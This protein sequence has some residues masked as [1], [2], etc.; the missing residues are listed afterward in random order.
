ML[1]Y[2]APKQ[3][4][5]LPNHFIK[6]KFGKSYLVWFQK[7]NL[8]IRLEEPAWFVFNKLVKRW[9]AGTIALECAARYGL[10]NDESS[11]YVGDIRS[12]IEKM[13]QPANLQWRDKKFSNNIQ[14]HSFEPFAKHQYR[15]NNKLIIFTFETHALENYLHPLLN[16][17]ETTDTEK[18]TSTFEL[19][20]FQNKIV[21]RF[22][23]EVM[24]VW[25]NEE[26]HLVKGLVFMHLINVFFDKKD[27]FWMMT[28][29]ASA[30]TNGKKTILFP[31][32]PGS[33]KTTI[34]ALLQ[35]RGF[36]LVSDDF[37]PVDR[38][39]GRAYPFPL[40]ISVKQ[41]SMD[42]LSPIFPDLEHKPSNVITPEKIVRYIFPE[43]GQNF[44][45]E[46]FPVKEFIFI[47]Y[48]SSV[49]FEWEEIDPLDAFKLL[50]EETW[51]SP[52]DGIA[53]TIFD[54]LSDWS[55]YKLTYSN[56]RK[57]LEAITKLFNENN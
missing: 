38:Y 40:A 34:A 55:F 31:A 47:Q 10:N 5:L 27:D 3:S 41:G 50:L 29:H 1:I 22:N 30:I 25:K 20:N 56:N 2:V 12:A 24:G 54:R 8:Y 4:T 43:I 19:F 15:F 53:N 36:A 49:D 9:K 18:I 51:V 6:R 23:R 35:E 32:G 46:A 45:P 39:S 33:G 14:D 26:S 7:S 28:V 52:E 48:D 44:S 42:I 16:H 21:F 17:L 37:V 57:A 13:N 11:K